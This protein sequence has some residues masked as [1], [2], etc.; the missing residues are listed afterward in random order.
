MN[1]TLAESLNSKSTIS[2]GDTVGIIHSSY[3]QERL[4]QLS[5]SLLVAKADLAAKSTGEKKALIDEAKNKVQYTE[6]AIQQ[7]TLAFERAEEL[8]KKGY[9]PQGEYETYLWDLRQ[10]KILQEVNKAQLEALTTGS[11][12]EDLQVLRSTI[13]SYL[14]EMRL[15]KERLK[16]FV[17]TAPISGEIARDFSR[18]TLLKVN[19]TSQI[20]LTTPIRYGDIHFLTEGQPVRLSLKNLPGEITGQIVS[21]SKEITVLNGV[22]ILYA[23]IVLDSPEKTLVPG[24]L[25]GGEVLLPKITVKD[26]VFSV[27]RD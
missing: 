8:N 18:D 17:L 20:I 14:S 21:I 7:K 9:M 25:V 26:Y 23:R 10:T 11:K 6:A 22:Q 4:A 5:G 15:L 2:K 16:D 24:L 12:D 3:L 13:D 27:L 1:F 19:N